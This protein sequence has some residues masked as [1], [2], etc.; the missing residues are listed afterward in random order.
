M[1]EDGVRYDRGIHSNLA[2]GL[3][4]ASFILSG[5]AFVVQRNWWLVGRTPSGLLAWS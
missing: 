3:F 4:L 5:V 1:R 2:R